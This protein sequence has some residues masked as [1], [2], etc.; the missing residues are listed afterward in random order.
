MNRLLGTLMIAALCCIPLRADPEIPIA[1]R[2][3]N[4]ESGSCVWCCLDTMAKYHHYEFRF[5]GKYKGSANQTLVDDAL[6][7]ENFLFDSVPASPHKYMGFLKSRT[8]QDVPVMVALWW[9]PYT[10]QDG[11]RAW[12]AVM[13][14]GFNDGQ[15]SIV[16][17]NTPTKNW[18][19]SE[20][21]FQKYWVGWAVALREP[22][23]V[24]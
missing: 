8:K 16:D 20:E 13:V 23:T 6:R 21:A 3:P 10:K 9:W 12:H 18:T 2:V 1:D 22:L 11:P 7:R 14:T 24:E 5:L 17:P 19:W 4:D 15:V